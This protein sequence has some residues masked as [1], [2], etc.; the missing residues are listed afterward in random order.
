MKKILFFLSICS[1]FSL[2]INA[3]G[4]GSA[5]SRG[6]GEIDGFDPSAGGIGVIVTESSVENIKGH[7]YYEDNKEMA[8]VYVNGDMKVKCM[9]RYNAVDDEVE[10]TDN[11]KTYKMFKRDNIEIVLD[12][13]GYRYKVFEEENQKKYYILFNKGKVSL[14][15]RP[16]KKIKLGVKA[17]TNYEKDKPSRYVLQNDYFILTEEDKFIPV[18]FKK[19]EILAALSSKKDEVENFVSS[20]KLRFK[21]KEDLIK[22]IDHYNSL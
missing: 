1:V 15:L 20:K 6:P 10:T 18:K 9:V 22:I 2:T 19:K 4:F 7:K 12:K 14:A 21:K 13:K 8:S 5:S 16:K 3:Q 11:D 17:A